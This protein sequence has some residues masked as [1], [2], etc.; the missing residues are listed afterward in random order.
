MR[1]LWDIATFQRGLLPASRNRPYNLWGNF[2]VYLKFTQSDVMRG[3]AV[4][5]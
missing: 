3:K 1:Q 5:R 4:A 2:E